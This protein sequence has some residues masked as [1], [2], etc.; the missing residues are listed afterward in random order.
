MFSCILI[1]GYSIVIYEPIRFQIPASPAVLLYT[2]STASKRK[3]KE[4]NITALVRLSMTVIVRHSLSLA[5]VKTTHSFCPKLLKQRSLISATPCR[6][7][8][9][10]IVLSL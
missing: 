2:F 5:K 8:V 4:Q 10:S 6:V 7:T 3:R 9:T 1:T